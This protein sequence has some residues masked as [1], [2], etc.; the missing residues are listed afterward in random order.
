[1]QRNNLSDSHF[2]LY[3]VE[4][5][6][7]FA[8]FSC[9][10]ATDSDQDLNDFIHN[11]A[12]R[13]YRDRIAVSYALEAVSLPDVRLAFATLQNDA[14]I[15]DTPEALPEVSSLF[16]YKTYPAVKIGRLGVNLHYQRQGVGSA[17]LEMIKRLMSTA[18]RTGCRFLTVDARRDK[19]NKVDTRPFYAKNGFVELACR[20]K[21]SAYVPMYFDLMRFIA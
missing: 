20:D 13:H 8:G 5:F 15:A 16:S 10:S 1:V 17:F 18:N 14:I 7:V 2:R 4:D 12:A 6:A 11:D 21:T 3:P 9:L 19:K